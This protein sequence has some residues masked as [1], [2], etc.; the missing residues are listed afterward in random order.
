MTAFWNMAPCSLLEV[1][2]RFRDAYCFHHLGNDST[3]TPET[4]IY[5]YETIRRHNPEGCHLNLERVS[6]L[7]VHDLC[8]I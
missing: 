3:E 2:R 4:S 8:P 5:L 7:P 6:R 1:V